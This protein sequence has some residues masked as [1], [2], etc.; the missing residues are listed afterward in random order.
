M[1]S[2]FPQRIKAEV[3]GNMVNWDAYFDMD[4][5]AVGVQTVA[6]ENGEQ[7]SGGRCVWSGEWR[8]LRQD[9]MR[10]GL[11]VRTG[12]GFFKPGFPSKQAT[13]KDNALGDDPF[14]QGPLSFLIRWGLECDDGFKC[15]CSIS[16]SNLEIWEPLPSYC[17]VASQ[18]GHA[19]G[20]ATTTAVS[21]TQTESLPTVSAAV[22]THS[23]LG[24][25]TKDP[26]VQT[27]SSSLS[28]Q[29]GQSSTE[30]VACKSRTQYTKLLLDYQDARNRLYL[31]LN[32]ASLPAPRNDSEKLLELGDILRT[33]DEE[34][35]VMSGQLHKYKPQ[36]QC[37]SYTQTSR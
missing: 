25:A 5:K 36:E 15:G 1:K 6:W 18:A 12:P 26:G 16:G 23:F 29:P 11:R 22:Q 13:L 34:F 4:V 35:E 32:L 33:V 7:A 2:A 24:F 3:A 21:T 10:H 30:P 14:Y 27:S 37:D 17:S 20:I 9:E 8:P 19:M 31:A 28:A